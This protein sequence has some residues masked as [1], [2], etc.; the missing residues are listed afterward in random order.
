[1]GAGGSARLKGVPDGPAP[2]CLLLPQ[3]Q[4]DLIKDSGHMYFIKHLESPGTGGGVPPAASRAQAAFVLAA[5][6]DNHPRAQLL[7]SQAGLLQVRLVAQ[8]PRVLSSSAPDSLRARGAG[9][10]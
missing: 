10:A 9:G 8:R 4:G 5:T 7:C 6:C 1:M 3:V 2:R